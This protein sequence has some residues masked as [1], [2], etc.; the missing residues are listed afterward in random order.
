MVEIVPVEYNLH[1]GVFE[2]YSKLGFSWFD[3]VSGFSRGAV[4]RLEQQ[5]NFFPENNCH[6]VGKCV[7]RHNPC[8]H[9]ST[10]I[11]FKYQMTKL[12]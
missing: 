8:G 11:P 7:F 2:K 1:L 12:L 4:Y 3:L 10:H 6:R 9:M 5:F